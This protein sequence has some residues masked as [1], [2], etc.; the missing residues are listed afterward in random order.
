MKWINRILLICLLFCMVGCLYLIFGYAPVEKTMGVVQK[1][2]YFHLSSAWIG[3]FAFFVVFISGVAYLY[4]RGERWELMALASAEIGFVYTT[5]VLITGSLWARSIWNTWWSW[6]PRLTTTFVL[7]FIYLAYILLQGL[8]GK[9]ENR[10]RLAAVYGIIAFINVPMVFF[11]IRW[12]RAIH[13]VVITGTGF[14]LPGGMLDTLLFCLLTFS[15]LYLY[16]LN[17]RYQGLKLVREIDEL[18]E[19]VNN[20]RRRI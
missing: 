11:S 4:T 20:I 18:K 3:F 19:T 13:P 1:I 6:D 9:V 2:F 14:G 5:I 8:R 7:W 10:A 17:L 15:I 16:L 12:W